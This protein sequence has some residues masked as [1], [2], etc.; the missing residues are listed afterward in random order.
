MVR[1]EIWFLSTTDPELLAKVRRNLRAYLATHPLPHKISSC[2]EGETPSI[3]PALGSASVTPQKRASPY[4]TGKAPPMQ[5]APGFAGVEPQRR[6]SPY[7]SGKPP[8]VEPSADPAS[9]SSPGETPLA[10]LGLSI[11]P[12]NALM[13]RG[14]KTVQRLV[15]M[16]DDEI[17]E[18][19]NIG[20][21]SL[22]EMREKL[23]A[24]SYNPPSA[25]PQ[26]CASPYRSGKPPSVEPSADPSSVS[27]PDETPLAA[28]GLSV[29]S[30]NALMRRGIKTVQHLARMSEDEIL[31]VRNISAK[32][33]AEARGKLAAFSYNPPLVEP[34]SVTP[35]PKA[36]K[37]L[38]VPPVVGADLLRVLRKEGVPLDRISLERLALPDP[39]AN[40]IHNRAVQTLADLCQ[41]PLGTLPEEGAVIKR[42]HLYLNWLLKQD[43]ETRQAEIAGQ[44]ISP[45]H[46]LMLQETSLDA[47]IQ[48][49][50]SVLKVNE[51]QIIRW[52]YGLDGEELT[53][54]ATGKRLGLTRQRVSQIQNRALSR[55]RRP[56]SRYLINSLTELLVAVLAS[57]GGLIDEQQLG[58]A[59][60]RELQVERVDPVAAVH[61]VMLV[62]GCFEWLPSIQAW[63][64]KSR[65]TADLLGVQ[66]R[67][68]RVLVEH[69]ASLSVEELI[70]R[71]KA[72]RFYQRCGDQLDD[73]LLYAC[74]RAHPEIEINDK[75]LCRLTRW[76]GT[77]APD[78]VA[79]LRKLDHPAHYSEIAQAINTELPADRL[80]SSRTVHIRL[81]QHPELFVWVGR[82]GTYGLKEWGMERALSYVEALTQILQQAG[83]PV[84]FQE[85]LAQL[86]KI[87][88]Y[89]DETSIT[90][91]LGTNERFQSFADGTYGLAEWHEDEIATAEYRSQRLLEALDS[92]PVVRPKPMLVQAL[93]SVDDFIAQARERV[94]DG[95]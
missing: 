29:R 45:V 54:E 76:S 3:K 56:Q 57:A 55:L 47:L 75:G 58:E 30:Y 46:R 24:F 22:A 50:L 63:K 84:T 37:S 20:A 34:T 8:S 94:S 62:D 49:W 72:S 17:L 82:R 40:E 71:F 85:I 86:P 60:R 25:E 77:R 18:V 7:R 44:G 36:S 43:E 16:S 83:H 92:A 41:Q 79:A 26:R 10:A 52:R 27:S 91:T 95:T 2:E 89:Y 19:R 64:L 31:E 67:L 68:A 61:L 53:C 33:L 80:I 23:A 38:F 78:I 42:L 39:V 51:Q 66:R 14:I 93:D 74:L 73:A 6:A 88:P 90:I 11:R 1:G 35:E 13:R 21:N 5:S 65:S 15:R 81:M 4:R 48:K 28:L 32:S 87:R 9:A 69:K 12:Y 70:V 59:L